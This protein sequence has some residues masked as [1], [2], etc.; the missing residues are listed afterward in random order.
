MISLPA[1]VFCLFVLAP[2]VPQNILRVR[3]SPSDH[4]PVPNLREDPDPALEPHE[5]DLDVRTLLRKLGGSFDRMYLSDTLPLRDNVS[6]ISTRLGLTGPLPREIRKLDLRNSPHGKALRV[7]GR[8]RQKFRQWLWSFT[9]CPVLSVWKDLGIRF[10]PRY[11][12]EGRC[13]KERSCSLP[14]GMFCKPVKS[15][16]VKL[17]RWQCQG[18]RPLRHCTWIRAH[19]PVISKCKCT[20]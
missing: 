15:V 2:C 3:P 6:T 19:Y 11:V 16:T 5:E 17:L 20:C 9:R 14:E 7:G 12:K 8:A 1:L 4:L 18:F 13:E 10:W